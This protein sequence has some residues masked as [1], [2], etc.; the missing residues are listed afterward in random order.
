MES[1]PQNPDFKNNPKN[2]HPRL[3]EDAG[4]IYLEQTEYKWEKIFQHF[5]ADFLWK[6]NLKILNS[7]IILRT[8]TRAYHRGA[9]QMYL[10]IVKLFI[11]RGYF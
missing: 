11:F 6:V 10:H 4:Q 7:G 3:H 8:S 5:E 1:Q 9:G 2:F